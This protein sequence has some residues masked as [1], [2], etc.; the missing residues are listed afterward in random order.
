MFKPLHD[1]V[2]VL[3]DESMPNAASMIIPLDVT[4]WRGRDNAIESMNRGTI[5]DVGPGKRHPKTAR[6]RAM[7]SKAGDVIRFSELE[8][9]NE[10]IDGRTYVLI[11][12]SDIVGLEST[13]DRNA[14][15][16]QPLQ[17]R[18]LIKRKGQETATASGIVIPEMASEKPDQGEVM[19]IGP[20]KCDELGQ[21]IPMGV[22]V[23]DKVLFGKFSGQAVKIEGDELIV[24]RE[25]DLF[26]VIV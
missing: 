22:K 20:G 14:M 8:Y 6:L 13:S 23:G 2:L 17:D 16:L 5:A 3:L 19:A 4:K 10:R 9:P 11:S 24:M 21:V 12:E 25:E 1:R 7:Q 26:A 18:V 15:N